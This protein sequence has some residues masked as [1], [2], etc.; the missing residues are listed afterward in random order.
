LVKASVEVDVFERS[1]VLGL[2]SYIQ[3]SSLRKVTNAINAKAEYLDE[4]AVVD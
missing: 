3:L 2:T 1:R 4:P